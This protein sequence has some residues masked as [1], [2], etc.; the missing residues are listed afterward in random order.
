MYL[1]SRSFAVAVDPFCRDRGHQRP[2]RHLPE[3]LRRLIV[4]YL[5]PRQQWQPIIAVNAA[6][7]EGKNKKRSSYATYRLAKSAIRTKSVH[8]PSINAPTVL[9]LHLASKAL[10]M[11]K[12][13]RAHGAGSTQAEDAAH[14]ISLVC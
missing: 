6:A 9:Q 14:V 10:L 5:P 13:Y 12:T 7:A 4:E 1:I 8:Q 2:R 3:R 11:L